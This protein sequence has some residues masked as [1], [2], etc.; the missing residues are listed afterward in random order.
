MQN[1]TYIILGIASMQLMFSCG[2]TERKTIESAPA[3]SVTTSQALKSSEG[4]TV[5]ASGKIEAATSANLS[6]RMMGNVTNVHVKVGNKVAK[7]TLLISIQNADLKAKRGQIEAAILQA[8]AANE[9]AQKDFERFK[10][11]FAQGS[12]SQKELDD[13]TTRA[14][15]TKS[16]LDAALQ[17]KKEI[18]A[19][20]T[21]AEI[22]APYTCIV[23]NTFVK[24]G[25]MASPGMPL[26][27]V[28]STEQSQ[29]IAMVSESD[30]DKIKVG[31]EATVEVKSLEK[32]FPAKVIEVSQSAKNTGGQFI[33]KLNLSTKDEAVL[34]GMF[35]HVYFNVASDSA[36][37]LSVLVAKSALVQKG[38]LTGIYTIG[39]ENT[40][41]L[42]W[43]RVGKTTGDQV[44]ILSGMAANETYITSS[45]GKLFNGAKV[46]IK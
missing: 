46:A 25:D 43:L 1:L 7:G 9:N 35:A 22:R 18:D 14:T 39:F 6:T 12:A 42:R 20:F 8:K 19:Q 34:S 36:Q 30:I 13:M 15:M 4:A 27:A 26:V 29:V 32:S 44:E 2:T 38:Q 17:M 23:T 31:T 16:G 33:V 40:A 28:E 11:L 21:Y 10:T 37:E 45:E 3:I 5:S 24:A 41:I